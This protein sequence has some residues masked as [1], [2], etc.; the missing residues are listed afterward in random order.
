MQPKE[1]NGLTPFCAPVGE[2]IIPLKRTVRVEVESKVIP[3]NFLEIERRRALIGIG[4]WRKSIMTRI[5]L[6]KTQ[7]I[8][9][10]L[11]ARETKRSEI[12][13]DLR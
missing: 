11:K 6:V 7:V 12:Y 2:E 9:H 13:R 8:K 5:K 10:L 1:T 4:K 3:T